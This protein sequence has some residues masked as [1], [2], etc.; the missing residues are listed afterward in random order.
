VEV[1][2]EKQ[3]EIESIKNIWSHAY[4]F[5]GS[6]IDNI[7]R[8]INFIIQSKKILKEDIS[9][10]SALENDDKSKEIKVADVKRLIGQISLTPYGKERVAIIRDCQKLNQSSA[11]VLLKSIE[12]PAGKIT[13]IL[14]STSQDVLATIKSRCRVYV[15]PS[16]PKMTEIELVLE[17]FLKSDLYE[18]DPMIEE[19]VKSDQIDVFLD[20]VLVILRENL[21][22]KKNREI[23]KKIEYVEKIRKEIKNNA[24]PKLALECLW[25]TIKETR[26]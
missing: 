15:F 17:N 25:L 24:N 6:D 8:V 13:F 18:V 23:V 5:V 2:V 9:E 16:Q 4:L 3:I 10:V 12:E 14:T 26:S 22:K 21:L 11:N 1:K 7:D 19:L 20:N